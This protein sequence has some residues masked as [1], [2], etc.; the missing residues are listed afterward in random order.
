MILAEYDQIQ[1][2]DRYGANDIRPGLTGW[3]Q[4]NGRDG[5]TVEQKARLD[6]LGALGFGDLGKDVAVEMHRAAPVSGL[7]E[8]L[9]DRADHAGGLVAGEHANAAQP[10]RLQ[11]RQEIAPAL[12]RLGEA[13]GAADHLAVAVLARAYGDHHRD[14]LVRAAPAALEVDSVDVEVGIFAGQGPA[15]SLLDCREGFLVEVGHGAGRHARSPQGL[16]DVF[17][18]A[19]RRRQ[20]GTSRSWLPLCW[21]RA[22]CSARSRRWRSASP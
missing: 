5:V 2:R 8:H 11:P 7:R 9:G 20:R 14:V 6:G 22:F 16:A 1:A 10:A 4:V 17:D 18:A 3:A 19:R 21:S 13:L 12:G 15:P